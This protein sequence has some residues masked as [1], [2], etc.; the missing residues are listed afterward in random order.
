L[1]FSNDWYPAINRDHVGIVDDGISAIE[2]RGVRTAD[3]VLHEADVIIWGTGFAATDFL[4]GIDVRGVKASLAEAWEDGAHA[5]LGMTVP[6]FPNLF[7]IYGPNTNLGG[8]SIV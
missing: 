2:S 7:W 8:G 1:L 5:H 6:G 4:G 3:G